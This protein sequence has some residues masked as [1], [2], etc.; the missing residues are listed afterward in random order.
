MSKNRHTIKRTF[1]YSFSVIAHTNT[2]GGCEFD[3]AIA[4]NIEDIGE[5]IL[6]H[7]KWDKK[8]SGDSGFE[9][10]TGYYLVVDYI[11]PSGD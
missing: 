3:V 9:Y 7:E 1:D 5:A 4:D 2:E 10:N 8:K 6:L 11:E